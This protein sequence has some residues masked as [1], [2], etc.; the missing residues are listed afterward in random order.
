MP[1]KL[2]LVL[3]YSYFF[4]HYITFKSRTN[5]HIY[6]KEKGLFSDFY[7]YIYYGDNHLNN[8]IM[9][10]YIDTIIRVGYILVGS[11]LVLFVL[12]YIVKDIFKA[13]EKD[14]DEPD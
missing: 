14:S 6:Y 10:E 8:N 3:T 2:V 1:L 13:Y 4:N 5:I 11:V 9:E 7:P 12:G